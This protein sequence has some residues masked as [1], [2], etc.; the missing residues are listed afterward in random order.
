MK[1]VYTRSRKIFSKSIR[2]KKPNI[3]TTPTYLEEK[4]DS[5]LQHEF[6]TDGSITDMRLYFSTYR[7]HG[8]KINNG[9]QF[10]PDPRSGM[11]EK[12][13][14]RLRLLDYVEPFLRF[15]LVRPLPKARREGVAR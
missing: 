14:I 8:E 2:I 9:L 13:T 5:F 3:K 11:Q 10:T 1:R 15:Q 4:E 6:S 12:T 7:G